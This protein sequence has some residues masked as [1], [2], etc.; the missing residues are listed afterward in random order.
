M[1][2]H[3][4]SDSE[5]WEAIAADSSKAFDVL[6][7]R[8]WTTIYATAFSYLKDP[9]ICTQIVHD[10]FLKIWEKRG[11]YHISQFKPYLTS[12]ARYHVY[13]HLKARKASALTYVEDY[14][15]FGRL[16]QSQNEGDEHLNY[17]ELEHEL[18]TTLIKLPKRCREIFALSRTDQLSNEEISERLGISKRSVE[19]QL[20]TALQFIRTYLKY[21]VIL[22]FLLY[23]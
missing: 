22:F 14:E 8:Y 17:L 15:S 16:Q 1:P 19:N 2:L 4:C 21:T 13:K 18:N 3:K 12:A 10:I 6:F 23:R 20:T 7:E 5:L 9:E 11:V